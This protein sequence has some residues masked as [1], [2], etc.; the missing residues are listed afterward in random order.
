MEV[1][2]YRHSVTNTVWEAGVELDNVSKRR[3][4][5][6]REIEIFVS[7]VYKTSSH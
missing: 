5:E 7:T 2:G 3:R 6:K 1:A 4:R